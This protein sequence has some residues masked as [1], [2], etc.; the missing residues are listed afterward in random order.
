[1]GCSPYTR[2]IGGE[3]ETYLLSSFAALVPCPSSL[4]ICSTI[5]DKVQEVVDIIMP[6]LVGPVCKKAKGSGLPAVWVGGWRSASNMISPGLWERFVWPY[7]ERAV[8][9]VTSSGL[10]AILHLDSNWTRDS[11]LFQVFTERQVH[12]FDGWPNRPVQGEAG[13]WGPDVPH[14][15]RP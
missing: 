5:P 11:G 7:I 14:G 6:H 1:M 3:C 4:V 2:I 12:S 9:E 13:T 8:H 15:R 10:I